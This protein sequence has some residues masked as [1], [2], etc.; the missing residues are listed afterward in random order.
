MDDK[1]HFYSILYSHLVSQIQV[2]LSGMTENRKDVLHENVLICNKKS[3]EEEVQRMINLKTKETPDEKLARLAQEYEELGEL[4]KAHGYIEDRVKLNPD[5]IELWRSYGLFMLRNYCH[6]ERAEECLREAINLWDEN[7]DELFLAYGALMVQLKEKKKALIFLTKVGNEE[8]NPDYYMKS[9]L[10][11]SILYN[12]LDE[13]DLKKKH[14]SLA[15][16]MY[17]REKGDVSKKGILKENPSEPETSDSPRVLLTLNEEQTDELYIDLIESL[18]IP[19]GIT[20]LA[21]ETIELLSEDDTPKVTKIK[22]KIQFGERK[23]EEVLETL[24][25]YLDDNKFDVEA[26]VLFADAY[27]ALEKY[28]ESEKAYL[29]ALR[30]GAKDVS[31]KKKLGLIFIRLKKWREA[32]TVFSEYCNEIDPK[33]AYAWRFLGMSGWKL[34][35]IEGADT[36]FYFSNLLDNSNAETWGLLTINWLITGVAQNRAFQSYQKAIRLGLN[37]AEI[38]SELAYL[39]TKTKKTHKD[40]EY[41][42]DKA[43][44]LDPDQEDLWI[45]YAEFSE[46]KGNLKKTMQWYENALKYIK[47]EV[48]ERETSEKLTNS[49]SG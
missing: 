5:S 41:C 40:A 7:D 8:E 46:Q 3:S 1:D 42:F 44:T 15:A 29:R 39:L 23:F 28:D 12:S 32:L 11:L 36:A 45:K 37:N 17:L 2:C 14:F 19:E 25:D 16:K 30:R 10:L 4:D 9:H 18:L 49:N 26:I 47:G 43:L 38:F 31:I 22:A 35:I 27:Y 20:Q 24:E 33:W 6:L 13:E 34:R 21:S 48:K